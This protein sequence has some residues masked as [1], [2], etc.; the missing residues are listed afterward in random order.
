M[1]ELSIASYLLEA[2][3]DHAHEIGA[4]RVLA[5]NLIV[6]ER[7]GVVDDSL[8]FSFEMLAPGTLAEGAQI[9]TQRTAMRFHC[10]GCD[11]DYAPAAGD[12]CCPRCGNYGQVCDDGSALVIESI[13]VET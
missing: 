2:V 6:G 10:A 12:F 1:H 4:S 9:N 7:A 11:D 5:I 8:R 13:E 3:I